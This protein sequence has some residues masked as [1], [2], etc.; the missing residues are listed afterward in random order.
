MKKDKSPSLHRARTYSVLTLILIVVG[1]GI[2]YWT[3]GRIEFYTHALMHTENVLQRTDELY[4][5]MLERE[6]NIRGYVITRNE[7]FLTNYQQSNIDSEKLLVQLQELTMNNT[8]QQNN[9][10]ELRGLIN[11][12]IRTFESTLAHL[13]AH[14]DLEGFLGPSRIA[15]AL[16]AYSMTK[17]V[18]LR[19]NEI[20]NKLF[21]ER[22]QGLINNINALPFIVGLISV[23][24]IIMGFI[25]FF[26]I[27]KY[28]K[29]QQVANREI[30][31]FQEKLRDQIQLLDDSNKE[32]EQFAYVASHDLQEPLRKITA[33]SDLLNEQYAGQLEGD[34]KLYL[35]RITAAAVRMRNLITDLLE[36][37]RAG[38]DKDGEVKE[39]KLTKVIKEIIE[40]I[41]ITIQEK[42]AAINYSKLPKVY[43][44]ETEFRQVFQNLISNALK[45][46]KPDEAPVI[47]ITSEAAPAK[48]IEKLPTLD[49]N[50]KYHLIK[51]TD[52]GIGFDP[53]YADR[54]FSIFQ[55]LHGKNEYEGTGIGLSITRKIIEKREGLIY[56]ESTPGEGSVFHILLPVISA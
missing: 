24:S 44:L 13:E 34:G 40:D 9:I 7:E 35:N 23:F 26:S 32:L 56:A 52:N 33:F 31:A 29:A 22:N 14:G 36:Y 38:R 50:N 16:D 30:Q 17:A 8:Q 46:S 54:I 19:I 4:A 25:T 43:G 39:I 49:Q 42:S 2:S 6:S 21:L 20:E 37:S 48:L 5:S 15:G 28:N 45:F 41:E 10:E 51:V 1:S 11:M 18:I 12:R 27:Y 47:N 3:S 53:T 55:R